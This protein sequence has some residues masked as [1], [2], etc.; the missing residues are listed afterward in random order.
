MNL[1]KSAALIAALAAPAVA[2]AIPYTVTQGAK[3]VVLVPGAYVDATSTWRLIHDN[4]WIAG[5]TVTVVPQ[6]GAT[7][8]ENVAATRAAIEAQ[9]GPVVLVGHDIGGMV[10]SIA[11]TSEKVKS[12]VYIAALQPAAGE[13]ASALL[14]TK[15][16][17]HHDYRIG[18]DGRQAILPAKFSEV[19]AG[20]LP[21]NRTNFLKVAQAPVS[22]ATL[23]T[24]SWEAA[25]RAKPSYAIVATEDRVINP[26]LQRWMYQRAGSKIVE[27]KAS[28]AL[29]LA[30]PEDVA[31]VIVRA[32]REVK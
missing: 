11:G 27:I 15:P 32:A 30:K 19:Y 5:Y 28:H 29:N 23:N 21:P 17:L 8:D 4:L 18:A 24:P 31:A 14:A 20:D 7:L 16:A 3:H 26:E 10:I 9:E 13:S 1:I 22:P 2:S 25:W 6:N 12:L